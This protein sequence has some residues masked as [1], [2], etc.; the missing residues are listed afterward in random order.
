MRVDRVLR[1]PI[2]FSRIWSN[3]FFQVNNFY[4]SAA[5][6]GA[7]LNEIEIGDLSKTHS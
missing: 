1:L 6:S 2:S 4:R 7:P 5:V 3:K